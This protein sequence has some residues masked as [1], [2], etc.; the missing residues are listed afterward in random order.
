M[1]VK[2]KKIAD[3]LSDEQHSS[4]ADEIRQGKIDGISLSYLG[5]AFGPTWSVGN[6]Y[7]LDFLKHYSGIRALEVFLPAL[8]SIDAIAEHVNE[9]EFL[10][11]GELNKKTVSL[12]PLSHLNK[13][14][15]LSLVKNN[16]E[17]DSIATLTSL[18]D[19]RLTGYQEKQIEHVASLSNLESLYLGFGTFEDLHAIK[20]LS[21]LTNLEILWV[22]K[23]YDLSALENLTSLESLHLSTLKQ[24]TSIPDVSNLSH[25]KSLV[26]DTMNGL[27]SL[28]GIKG[29]SINELAVINS[30]VDPVLF[31]ELNNSLPVL[32]R[33]VLGLGT[34]GKTNEASNFFDSSVICDTLNDLQ[35]S[36][37][38]GSRVEFCS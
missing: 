9:I 37:N 12:S 20:G 6:D 21:K 15:Y 31:S 36:G 13:L 16:K 1:R 10:S 18:R 34:K 11:L 4:I 8:T 38:R 35:Y 24:V 32:Q 25:L 23:L 22:K 27:S 3:N 17:I 14:N 28:S 2:L 29:S 26:M 5:G 30:K 7:S 19:L 33:L